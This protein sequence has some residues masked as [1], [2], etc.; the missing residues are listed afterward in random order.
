MI[1][2][3]AIGQELD[4]GMTVAFIQLGGT[5]SIE[6]RTAKIVK[7]NRTGPSLMFEGDYHTYTF[8]RRYSQVVRI[9]Q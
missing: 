2:K 7:L 4:V 1:Y 3:D 5:R 6:E 8:H 9:Q